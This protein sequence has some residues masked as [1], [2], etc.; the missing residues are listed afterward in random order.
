[1]NI[2]TEEFGDLRAGR[3]ESDELAIRNRVTKTS[4]DY[5]HETLNVAAPRRAKDEVGGISPGEDVE[6]VVGDDEK[7]SRDRVALDT[8]DPDEYD[9]TFYAE[10]TVRAAAG[11]LGPFGYSEKDVMD[12][13]DEHHQRTLP[14]TDV[15][16]Q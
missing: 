16:C 3:V 6:Y 9:A 1:M 7:R 4:A 2:T 10:L 13:I 11:V 12:A 5:G 15:K 8:E 14:R